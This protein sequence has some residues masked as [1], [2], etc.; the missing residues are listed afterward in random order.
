MKTNTI[1][2]YILLIFVLIFL[3]SCQEKSDKTADCTKYENEIYLK[4][5]IDSN[6]VKGAFE[7]QEYLLEKFGENSVK[8][9]NHEAYH[10][11]YYSS[12]GFGKLIKVEKKLDGYSISVKC[13]GKKDL[14]PEC[15]EYQIGIKKE[16]WEEFENLIYEFNFWTAEDF[17]EA[18]KVLDGDSF[19]LEGNRPEAE[20]C[21]KKNYKLIARGSPRFD[22]MGA[23]CE[24]IFEYEYQLK[25]KYIQKRP[26]LIP[27]EK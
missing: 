2:G 12:H 23:L 16:E 17:R 18:R 21:N 6:L 10:L 26:S 8:D 27:I 25:F 4:W 11:Q 7:Y 15:K 14:N 9:L 1:L 3:I 22:K 20:K 24:Y 13:S 5:N 19:L